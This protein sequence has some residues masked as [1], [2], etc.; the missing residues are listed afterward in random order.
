MLAMFTRKQPVMSNEDKAVIEGFARG[1]LSLRDAAIRIHRKNVLVVGV[2]GNLH[3]R[4]MAEIDTPVPD[5]YL[6]NHYRTK[7]LA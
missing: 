3:Q 4:F 1:D 2:R 7:L 6:R 5:L